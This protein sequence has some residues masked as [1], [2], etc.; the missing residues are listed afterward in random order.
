L[1]KTTEK[2]KKNRMRGGFPRF[3][4]IKKGGI[5]TKGKNTNERLKAA[6][7]GGGVK[8]SRTKLNQTN[9]NHEVPLN[10]WRDKGG[11][12]P[13]GWGRD[14]LRSLSSYGRGSIWGGKNGTVN[15]IGG[16]NEKKIG[17]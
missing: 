10:D 9:G 14:A 16:M 13:K 15:D 8:K 7:K 6:K 17:Q 11:G 3:A 1:P 5:L 12:T 2:K 4:T